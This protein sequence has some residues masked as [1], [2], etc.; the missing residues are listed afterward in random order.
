MNSG[1]SAALTLAVL[2]SGTAHAQDVGA[3]NP[4]IE[5]TGPNASQPLPD[6][7]DAAE[8][9]TTKVTAPP[10]A[11]V[12]G[13]VQI[14]SVQ[15]ESPNAGI[16]QVMPDWTPPVDPTSGL[17]L[18]YQRGDTLS[19]EW[20]ERQFT[21]NGLV[22][23]EVGLDR[24]V[25]LVQLINRAFVSNGF[26]N[27]GVLVD[28]AAPTDGGPLKLRLV[29]GRLT[30]GSGK[31]PGLVVTWGANGRNRLSESYISARMPAAN[32][33]PVNAVA[34][35]RQFRLLAENPAIRTVSADLRPGASPGEAQLALTVDPEPNLDVYVSTANSRSPSIGGE[36][37]AVG[38]SVRNFVQPGDIFSAETG[39]TGGEQDLILGYEGPFIGT[40]TL[41]RGRGGF[42][43]AAVIDPQLRPLNITASDWQAEGGLGYRLI[44]RPLTPRIGESGWLS[45]RTLTLGLSVAHRV[46]ET[47]LLGR[48]FSFS[49]GAVNGRSEYTA[50]RLTGDF[51]ERGIGTVLAVSLTATQGLNGSKSVLPNLVSPDE[52][53][54][55]VRG[56]VSYARRLSESG[57]ELR[58][59]ISGQYAD[60]ILFSGERFG[61]GGAQTVRGYRETLVLADTGLNGSLELAQSFDLAKAG[62]SGKKFSWGK[63][64]ASVFVDGALLGNRDGP[65][66][67]PS[68]IASVGA[69][70]AWTPS[71][72]ISARVTYGKSLIDTPLTGS[73][74]LQDRGFSF[75]LTFRPLEFIR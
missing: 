20:V 59:R 35:E 18:D 73:K 58:A 38:G 60:G 19:A 68:E 42:N 41:I 75:R 26:I 70:L 2:Y 44:E 71:P 16:A 1:F 5:R 28:G 6:F 7:P 3:D 66:A 69:T 36:R 31:V 11:P 30:G 61:G 10:I 40:K 64:S 25:S 48:P 52:G 14:Y 49:P 17:V 32:Q 21:A 15:I 74:D 53:F 22:G 43:N 56:Q 54:R 12:S 29:Y 45:A 67:I 13:S 55:A 9:P 50:L 51:V 72:A 24:I 57:L 8:F 62:G 47:T 33:T 4:I 65:P 39:W 63:F 46:S 34:I 27:S 37:Y 23:P